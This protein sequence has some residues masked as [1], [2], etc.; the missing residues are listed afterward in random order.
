VNK[1]TSAQ[2]GVYLI[3]PALDII[4]T[5]YMM[6]IY[7]LTKTMKD[8][9][10]KDYRALL[11][12]IRYRMNTGSITVEEAQEE[13]KPLLADMNEKATAISKTYGKKHRPFTFGY[14]MR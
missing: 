13:A 6:R 14:L 4:P 11:A 2:T 12:D 3:Q 10:K 9:N 5:S 7:Q 8:T 1:E